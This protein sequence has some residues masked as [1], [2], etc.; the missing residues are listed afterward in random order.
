MSRGVSR[1]SRGVS[2]GVRYTVGSQAASSSPETSIARVARGAD[3]RGLF[4]PAL[5]VS[6]VCKL[7]KQ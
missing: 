1:V 5:H 2:L 7:R 4:V 6:V 3:A